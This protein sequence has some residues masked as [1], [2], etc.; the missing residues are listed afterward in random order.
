MSAGMFTY[1]L[2]VYLFDAPYMHV[3]YKY[4]LNACLMYVVHMFTKLCACL[5]DVTMYMHAY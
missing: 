4:M 3:Y 2:C 1:T 5:L